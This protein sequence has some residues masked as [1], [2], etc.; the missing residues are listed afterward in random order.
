MHLDTLKIGAQWFRFGYWFVFQTGHIYNIST[1][2]NVEVTS[3]MF[4]A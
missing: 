2:L 4:S 3:A 1:I